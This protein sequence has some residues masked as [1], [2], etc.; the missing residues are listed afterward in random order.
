[1]SFAEN[2]MAG[3][4][5]LVTGGA[6]GIG[7]AIVRLLGKLGARVAITSRKEENLKAAVQEFAE[8]D[9]IDVIYRVGDVRDADGIKAVIADIATELGGLDILVC[10]AAGNFICPTEELSS[11]GWRTVIDIDLN[12]TFNCCQ[13]A[14]PFLKKATRGGR[15]VAISTTHADSGWPTAAHAGAAKAGI[16]NLMK[17]LSAEWGK[18][19]VRANWVSPGPIE[20]TEG[21]DRLIIAQGKAAEVLERIPLGTFGQGEDIANAVVFLSSDMGAYV[22]GTELVVDGAA[23][24][25]T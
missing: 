7:A 24:W 4:T 2:T 1:M 13:A 3:K 23:R 8:K 19:G 9:G 6:T 14:L 25:G 22:S 5:A 11:N 18:Y 10:N 21:V 20:G 17:S 16:Q 12:G 15:I